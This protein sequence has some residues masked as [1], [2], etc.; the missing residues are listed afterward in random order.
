[1][2]IA[3]WVEA[4]LSGYGAAGVDEWI[5]RNE[6]LEGYLTINITEN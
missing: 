1:V 5:Y 4:Q 2:L 3:H 6:E